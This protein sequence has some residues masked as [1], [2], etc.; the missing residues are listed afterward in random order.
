MG[1]ENRKE[2]ICA[3]YLRLSF[4]INVYDGSGVG[5]RGFKS[6]LQLLAGSVGKSHNLSELLFLLR[7]P[8]NNRYLHC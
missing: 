3:F 6:S 8:R 1:R 5:L 7:K 2:G 4:R